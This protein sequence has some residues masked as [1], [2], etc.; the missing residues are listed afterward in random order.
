MKYIKKLNID[1][2]NWDDINEDDFT[3]FNECL[4]KNGE[5]IILVYKENFQQLVNFIGNR[6]TCTTDI[7]H[8]IDYYKEYNDILLFFRLSNNNC[9]ISYLLHQS[10]LNY[11]TEHKYEYELVFDF[12]DRSFITVDDLINRYK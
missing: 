5:C 10:I 2:N 11:M 8:F 1:F 9:Y 4:Y 6:L 7:K 12:N 3:K